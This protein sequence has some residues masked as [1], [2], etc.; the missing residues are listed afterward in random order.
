MN[1]DQP[2]ADR[3]AYARRFVPTTIKIYPNSHGLYFQ[4]ALCGWSN[5]DT[6]GSPAMQY[7][8]EHAVRHQ[9]LPN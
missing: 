4:C 6:S 9:A 8:K 1:L 3:I 5:T 2:L 7:A